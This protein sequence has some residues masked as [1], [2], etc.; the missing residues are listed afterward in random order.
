MEYKYTINKEGKK[1]VCILAI[2]GNCP[3]TIEIPETIEVDGDSYTVTQLYIDERYYQMLNQ[4][5]TGFK[6]KKLILPNSVIT[7]RVKYNSYI[8]EIILPGNMTEIPAYAFMGTNHL[9]KIELPMNLKKIGS[10]AFRK[11]SALETINIP[12]AISVTEY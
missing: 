9:R 12:E 7:V 3:D 8:E 4:N 11:C 1:E 5:E 6:C 10:A 2:H